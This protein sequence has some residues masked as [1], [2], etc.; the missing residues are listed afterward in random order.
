MN[1]I[2]L[3]IIFKHSNNV[4][5]KKMVR[6]PCPT[7]GVT[8]GNIPTT[9]LII[10]DDGDAGTFSFVESSYEFKENSGKIWQ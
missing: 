2:K 1:V 7:C 5:I 3:Y 8:I 9:E 4:I 10:K 6:F